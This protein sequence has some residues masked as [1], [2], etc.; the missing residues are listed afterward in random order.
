MTASPFH[1]FDATI[2]RLPVVRRTVEPES[3]LRATA[4][5]LRASRARIFSAGAAERR[6]IERDLHDSGQN[7]LVAL[8]IKLELAAEEAEQ[9]GASELLHARLV[10]LC[11][12][13]QQALDAVRSIAHG[14][15]PPLL[16]TGGVHA[17]LEV[18]AR[19]AARAVVLEVPGTVPRSTPEAEAAVYYCCLEALQNACK[20]AG[21]AARVT[22]R[23]A[24]N[25]GRVAFAVR[26]DGPGFAGVAVAQS[27]GLTHMRDRIQA[28]GGSVEFGS[29]DGGGAV[30]RGHVPWPSRSRWAA[31][32][33]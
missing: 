20:H 32:A 31:V 30:V 3:E 7:R 26:D 27:T 17:A 11:E 16:E 14:V 10:A 8:R 23:L 19:S 2:L 13:A 21:P 25:G 5:E 6:R 9:E 24:Y 28:V 1:R 12:E 33:G 15:Y 18:E 4:R 29:C 22:V